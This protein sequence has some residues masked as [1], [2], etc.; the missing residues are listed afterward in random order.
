RN[1]VNMYRNMGL[2]KDNLNESMMAMLQANVLNSLIDQRIKVNAAKKI[3][4]HSS[5]DAVREI[6]RKQFVDSSGNFDFERYKKIVLTYFQKAPA[7]F[8]EDQ[9]ESYLGKMF[10]DLMQ[11]TAYVSDEEL[12]QTYA[13]RN[14]KVNLS[15]V[16]LDP[17]TSGSRFGSVAN[18]TPEE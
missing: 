3:G 10:D 14:D 11:K 5:E 15:F 7:D 12:R 6:I 2:L 16:E 18:P 9:M 13:L 17:S 8:E 4:L 1:I